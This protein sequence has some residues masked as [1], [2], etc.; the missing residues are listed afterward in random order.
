MKKSS[1][2]KEE[3]VV[4]TNTRRSRRDRVSRSAT[5][6]SPATNTKLVR[7]MTDAN[8]GRKSWNVEKLKR[9]D[10]QQA[11]ALL[12]EISNVDHDLAEALIKQLK[13]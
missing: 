8:A 7:S 13:G 9:L 3:E 12:E 6:A 11:V 10:P 1:L 2:N 5:G 4:P